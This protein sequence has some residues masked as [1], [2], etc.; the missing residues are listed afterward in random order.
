MACARYNRPTVR[1]D[2]A[3]SGD[4]PLESTPRAWTDL[5]PFAGW[6]RRSSSTVEHPFLVRSR[7]TVLR[8]GTRLE[9][10][11]TLVSRVASRRP[12]VRF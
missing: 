5:A 4:F 6:T 10:I 7:R 9:T 2:L 1:S 12:L 8:L 3:F 11:L